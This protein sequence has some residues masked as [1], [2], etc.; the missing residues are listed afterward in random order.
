MHFTCQT[1]LSFVACEV[2]PVLLVLRL[3]YRTVSQ[4]IP[5]FPTALHR[6]ASVSRSL[7]SLP[8][9][10]PL[11]RIPVS[12]TPVVWGVFAAGVGREV[13]EKK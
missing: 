4:T 2:K 3:L 11:C 10:A 1:L 7:P 12:R 9:V 5:L 8:L 13:Q 6:L